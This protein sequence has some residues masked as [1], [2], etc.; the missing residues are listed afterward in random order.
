MS[1]PSYQE[2]WVVFYENCLRAFVK[3]MGYLPS[4][5]EFQAIVLASD[6]DLGVE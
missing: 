5:E 1:N 2:E 4:L 6:Y 3:E